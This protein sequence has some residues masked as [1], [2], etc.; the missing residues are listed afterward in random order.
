MGVVIIGFALLDGAEMATTSS[1]TTVT[2]HVTRVSVSG[3]SG[4]A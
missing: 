3:S 4:S 2:S 1:S